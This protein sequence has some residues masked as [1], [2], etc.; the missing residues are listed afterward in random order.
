MKKCPKCGYQMSLNAKRCYD[1]G[2]EEPTKPRAVLKGIVR[3]NWNADLTHAP[4]RGVLME[5]D[6]KTHLGQGRPEWLSELLE[7]VEDGT[8]VT[9]TVEFGNK[10]PNTN[11]YVWKLTAPHT[12]TREKNRRRKE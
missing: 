12:Y 2:W 7:S 5:E 9:I 1:C 8:A 11:G 6:D 4:Y 3:H 10:H